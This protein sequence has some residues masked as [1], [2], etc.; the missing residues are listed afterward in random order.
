MHRV[1]KEMGLELW[2][3]LPNPS[4]GMYVSWSLNTLPRNRRLMEDAWAHQKIRGKT[5]YQ[6]RFRK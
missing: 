2:T 3:I 1:Y 4:L 5:Q 6:I